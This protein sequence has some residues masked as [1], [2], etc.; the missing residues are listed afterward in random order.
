MRMPVEEA[1]MKAVV[2]WKGGLMIAEKIV[3]EVELLLNYDKQ[4]AGGLLCLVVFVAPWKEV[5]GRVGG[6]M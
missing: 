1:M 3:V 5:G 6:G 4:A 2:T